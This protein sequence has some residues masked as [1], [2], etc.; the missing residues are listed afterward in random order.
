[1]YMEVGLRVVRG[2][3][4]TWEDQ[5]GGEGHAGTVIEVGKSSGSGNPSNSTANTAEK[6]PDKTVIVQWDRGSRS[7]YRIGYQGA[8]DLLVFDNA[9]AGIKHSNIICDGCKRHGIAGIRWKCAQCIDYDLCTQCYMADV[10]YLNH[11]FQ[12]FQTANA[13]GVQLTP[14]EGCTKIPLKGIFIGAKVVRGPDWEWGN[15]DDGPD[16]TG[17]VM[18]IRGWDNESSRSVATVTWSTGTT[19]VYRLGYKGCVDLC[20]VEEATCGTYY[21]QH[22]PVLG[23]IVMM[24]PVMDQPT[25]P[26]G[27]NPTLSPRHLSFNVGDKV[28]VLMEVDT[29]KQMQI[30]HGG[31]NPRMAEYIGKIGTVHRVTDKGDI[32]VQYESCNNRWTFHPGSLTKVTTKD[33]FTLGD[34]V[35]VKTDAT[36][37]KHYQRG[38]GEWIDVMKTVL[39]KTGKVIKIYSDGDIRVEFDGHTWTFNPAN[40]TLV[41]PTRPG[42]GGQGDANRFRDRSN[43]LNPSWRPDGVT[44]SGDNSIDNEVEKLL[45][46]AACGEAGVTAVKEFLRKNPGKV[47]ARSTR[48]GGGDKTCLQIAAHQG[49]CDICSLLIDAGA[50]LQAVDE[51]GDSP[52]HYAAFGNQPEIMELLVARGAAVDAVNNSKCSAL[53]VAVNK[54][55]AACVRIL[56]R[57][58]CDVNLQDEYGDTALHDAIG[59]DDLDIVEALCLCDRLDVTLRNRRG[60]NILHHAALKGNT[61]ATE[62]LVVKA[63]QLVDIK[64]EDGFAALHLAALNGHRDVVAT[65]LSPTGGCARVDLRN[66]RRQTPLHLA[67]SQGHLELVELLVQHHADI[68][69]QDEDGDTALHIAITKCR[70][71]PTSV[72]PT[73]GNSEFSVIHAISQN[74]LRRGARP[75][76]ALACFL[77]SSDNSGLLLEQ[78]RNTKGKS[79]LDLLHADPEYAALADLLRSYHT[80]ITIS[81]EVPSGPTSSPLCRIAETLPSQIERELVTESS[82]ERLRKDEQ[83]QDSEECATCSGV[84]KNKQE[85]MTGVPG[86]NVVSYGCLRCG[87]NNAK[88]RVSQDERTL[89]NEQAEDSSVDV[90]GKRRKEED[91]DKDLERLRYLESRVADLEEAN[92]CSICMERRR[93]VAF[94]CG[95]G[96]CEHCA[97]PLKTCH[98]CRKTITKKINLY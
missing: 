67:T 62:K 76:M 8:Y 89:E 92:T 57:H 12:R 32:R 55:H 33:T 6:T 17:R 54:Q 2:P 45:R 61:F 1:M 42:N 7:N 66:N 49:Q 47:D 52:L 77:V 37:V 30:G 20:Y 16:K 18:D 75:E 65:L 90:D 63:R 91:K 5:D 25:T 36:S 87:Q 60:F 26:N 73:D 58:G 15:Q 11:T 50:S 83:R 29:L 13:V 88:R 78:V 41:P 31:W 4:W 24:M 34:I 72:T 40:V 97:A 96:A 51:D 46:D 21:K 85:D 70:P 19:N 81:S 93:N 84:T 23:H 80:A 53:H 48:P 3:H 94:L 39:G 59:K 56:L 82:E 68:L 86:S 22:L 69:A 79:A 28:R 35:R 64:K 98:M 43:A 95:H 9:A 74:L 44:G 10:H 71:H 38:H 14:R 27:S